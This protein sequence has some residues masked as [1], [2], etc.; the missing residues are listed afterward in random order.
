MSD[1]R[2]DV[3]VNAAR[4]RLDW[5]SQRVGDLPASERALAGEMLEA[6]AVS[7]EGLQ[8]A[9]EVLQ[10]KNQELPD[11][12]EAVQ[13]NLE[14]MRTLQQISQQ[15]Q[16]LQTV[17]DSLAHP[18]YVINVADYTVEVANN[19]AR[20][21]QL[22]GKATCFALLHGRSR[23][24]ETDNYP[25][26]LQEL[27]NTKESTVVEHVHF[28]KDGHHQYV[29]I[30]AFPLADSEGK[31]TKMIEYTLDITERKEAE[32]ALRESESRWRSLTQTSP[33][34]ILMLDTDLT[35]RFANYASPGLT[36]DEL[37][38]KPLYTLVDEF[39]QSEIKAILEEV[40]R[41]GVPARYETV[42]P[43][44][45]DGDLHY[46]SHVARRILPD[47]DQ[48]VGLTLSARDITERKRTEQAL[49]DS[50]AKLRALFEILPIG[51]SVLDH[52][53]NIKLANPAL[54]EILRLSHDEVTNGAYEMRT[55]LQAD[56]REM[57]P[58]DFP[59][60]RAVREQRPV[61]NV[62]IGMVKEDGEQIWTSVSAAPLPF[63]DW[64][65]IVATADITGLKRAEVDLE[66][67]RDE[68][69][70]RV[71]R[72]NRASCCSSTRCCGPRLPSAS[73]WRRICGEARSAFAS[74]RSTSATS[75]GSPT[76]PTISS[77]TSVPPT[78]ICGARRGRWPTN[79]PP[80]FSSP[81]HPED[82]QRMASILETGQ[83]GR[84]S[85][86]AAARA[87]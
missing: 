40:L 27:L 14:R 54:A 76:W 21:D 35:V 65:V 12:T 63:D 60:I 62:E 24:C 87:A 74:S 75:S 73:R 77:C 34:H 36:I 22:Q 85:R 23:P 64:R 13:A 1:D 56:G 28:E 59:S 33:D 5:L 10:Q 39:R 49:R 15:N 37:V 82:R 8:A 44:P 46:E 43:S 16:F 68:L 84:A 7:V 47:T 26:P 79:S 3:E 45:D 83:V 70:L 20:A 4:E 72:T 61:R 86:R 19:A 50:E 69:E 2:F 32:L 48:V 29:E 53:R 66:Q 38:G 30:H 52:T 11:M 55:Y 9:G 6:F 78:R 71:D 25:C 57:Q 31:V 41:T 67:A 58:G 42:Y 17:L 81:V 80:L 51:L 18:F